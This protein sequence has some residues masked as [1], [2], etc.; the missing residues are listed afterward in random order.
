M[1]AARFQNGDKCDFALV[2]E[3]SI[4]VDFEQRSI[5]LFKL[6]CL[7]SAHMRVNIFKCACMITCWQV[8]FDD[9]LTF[10][11]QEMDKVQAG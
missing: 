3:H 4:K 11:I 7:S 6:R 1:L 2:L 10:S 5:M 8:G 9:A